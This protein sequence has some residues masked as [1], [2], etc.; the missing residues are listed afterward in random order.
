MHAFLKLLRESLPETIG[1]LAVAVILSIV[2]II[3]AGFGFSG[4]LI[5]VVTVLS[6][7]IL[8]SWHI[9]R[10]ISSSG[11][12]F[13][14]VRMWETRD[15]RGKEGG[16]EQAVGPARRE[17]ITGSI[18]FETTTTR[19][20]SLLREKAEQGCT[21]KF[22]TIRPRVDGRRIN[23]VLVATARAIG[24]K[25]ENLLEQI[26]SNLEI[27]WNEGQK[28]SEDRKQ[29]WQIRVHETIGTIFLSVDGDEPHGMLFLSFYPYS[30]IANNDWPI[31][32]LRPSSL[33][34]HTYGIFYKSFCKM[35]EEA[36]V[37]H[38]NQ[39]PR[40]K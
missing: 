14:P 16:F 28:L 2:G 24:K 25:P 27:I 20:L 11:S 18:N 22:V 38:P 29:H 19:Y 32:E 9:S 35:F 6:L 4:V 15:S 8:V 3:Y 10:R 39:Q 33:T 5:V 30:V 34:G 36:E 1:G 31:M 12:R 26:E 7:S 21:V 40:Q 37:W 17:I 23:P 13:E